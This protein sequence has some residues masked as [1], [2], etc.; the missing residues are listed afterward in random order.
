MK[1]KSDEENFDEAD[2]QAYRCWT[3]TTVP[4]DISVLFQDPALSSLTPASPLFFHLLFALQ[5]FTLRPPYTLPLTSTLPDMKSD[6]TNYIC[7]QNLYKTRAEEEKNIF[8]GLIKIPVDDDMVDTFVK[9]AHGLK[10]MRG[11]KWGVLDTN[12]VALGEFDSFS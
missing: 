7:L 6:T 9:N 10:V 4:S 11:T 5:Q 1:V 8:K 3:E 12:K 2:S